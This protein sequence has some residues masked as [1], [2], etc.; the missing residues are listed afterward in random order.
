[1]Q[2]LR[3]SANPPTPRKRGKKEERAAKESR[4]YAK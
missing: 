1:M 2:I 4:L 3:A